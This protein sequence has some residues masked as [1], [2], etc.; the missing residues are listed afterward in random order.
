MEGVTLVVNESKRLN[1]RDLFLCLEVI[2][3]NPSFLRQLLDM[4][5]NDDYHPHIT[6][7]EKPLRT[8]Y[9]VTNFDS[10][11]FVS[12]L[13]FIVNVSIYFFLARPTD[14]SFTLLR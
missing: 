4:K 1:R 11:N 3:T 5:E 6:L 8:Y 9:Y 7:L 10:P 13:F 12:S 14:K 2:S